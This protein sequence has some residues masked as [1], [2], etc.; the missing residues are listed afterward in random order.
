[1]SLV[2]LFLKADLEGLIGSDVIGALL[3]AIVGGGI[4]ILIQL[5]A[6]HRQE[7]LQHKSES[8]TIIV[9]LLEIA[10]NLHH[11]RNHLVGR[12][13]VAVAEGAPFKFLYVQPYANN[14]N[15]V[16]LNEAEKSMLL[17]WKQAEL[18]NEILHVDWIYNS[19]CDSMNEY[20]RMHYEVRSIPKTTGV[21][22]L[23]A[24]TEMTKEEYLEFAPRAA[25]LD[26]LLDQLVQSCK[27]DYEEA[28]GLCGL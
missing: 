3:G 2:S 21:Q 22:G 15:T 19:D 28:K 1:M 24:S 20:K 8:H 9:K 16:E 11:M 10:T 17:D 6:N 7:Y 18:F 25:E 27:R 5:Y 26:D 4:T 12:V 23:V 13:Q 14:V